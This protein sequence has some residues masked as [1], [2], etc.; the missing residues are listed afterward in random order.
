MVASLFSLVSEGQMHLVIVLGGGW[1]S[2]HGQIKPKILEFK[3]VKNKFVKVSKSTCQTQRFS[4]S[5][6]SGWI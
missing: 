1:A 4:T 2:S 6:I 3:I 5:T